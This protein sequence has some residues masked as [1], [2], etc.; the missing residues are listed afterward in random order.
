MQT[1]QVVE[2]LPLK[3]TEPISSTKEKGGGRDR[4][5]KEK[6]MHSQLGVQA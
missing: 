5:G 1:G 6:D 2:R 3:A 4:G